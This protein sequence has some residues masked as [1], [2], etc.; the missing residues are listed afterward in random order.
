MTVQVQVQ[1]KI[2]GWKSG[3]T[4]VDNVLRHLQRKAMGY[5]VPGYSSVTLYVEILAQFCRFAHMDPDQMVSLPKAEIEELI[6]SY[7]DSLLAKG[8]GRS[9]VKARRT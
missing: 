2:N 4:S 5:G 9:T 8:L 7:L 3:Y 6:H 1:M